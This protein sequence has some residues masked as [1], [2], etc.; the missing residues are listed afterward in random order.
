MVGIIT[1][2]I[3]TGLWRVQFCDSTE[4]IEEFVLVEPIT[5]IVKRLI[6]KICDWWFD[7]MTSK[8]VDVK[9]SF[10]LNTML[11]LSFGLLV[12]LLIFK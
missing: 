6:E 12:G 4:I 2:N 5:E 7:L 11:A 8:K 1:D 3:G 10:L 9:I